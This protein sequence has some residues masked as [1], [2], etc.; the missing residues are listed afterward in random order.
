MI[1]STSSPATVG[2]DFE[3]RYQTDGTPLPEPV[4]WYN[5]SVPIP[6]TFANRLTKQ[7]AKEAGIATQLIRSVERYNPSIECRFKQELKGQ[8]YSSPRL[9]SIPT[10]EFPFLAMY[11]FTTVILLVTVS[12][13]YRNSNTIP[14]P[15]QRPSVGTIFQIVLKNVVELCAGLVKVNS[16]SCVLQ[17]Y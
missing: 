13:P 9:H 1:R 17:L 10:G 4:S 8:F 15:S 16:P 7:H 12:P 3:I 14:I 5:N 6:S 11:C 2:D